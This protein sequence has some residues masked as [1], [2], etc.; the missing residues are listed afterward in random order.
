MKK[1]QLSLLL[2][3]FLLPLTSCAKEVDASCYYQDV[4]TSF[5]YGNLYFKTDVT[6]Y[7]D[8][9]R[10]VE[11]DATYSPSLWARISDSDATTLG[12]DNSFS[13]DNVTLL[14]GTTGMVN[15]AKYIQI[16]DTV[17]KGHAR[18]EDEQ[19]YYASAGEVA[20]YSVPNASTDS[21]TSDLARYFNTTPTDTYKLNTRIE[22]YYN[23]VTSGKIKILKKDGDNYSATSL[24]PSF[25]N[26]S[27]L[28]SVSASRVFSYF[29]GGITA[30]KTY[31]E[32]K[33]I[34]FVDS[35]KDNR[36]KGSGRH[37]TL[38]SQDGN[39][40][41]NSWQISID[42]EDESLRND[43][44]NHWEDTGISAAGFTQ[45][46]VVTLFTSTNNAFTAVEYASVR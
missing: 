20:V 29:N 19:A 17:Y 43:V 16:G 31:V 39:W 34:N 33:P 25:P 44:N 23:N 2:L 4:T 18:S 38:K 14:D 27:P 46:D 13:V 15:F 36:K 30:F 12:Q 6:A 10:K 42:W 21:D 5:A 40:Y 11:A 8:K 26:K 24:E 37:S 32:G 7:N 9:V 1:K 45:E 35:F 41:Y 22:S 3:P 28:V